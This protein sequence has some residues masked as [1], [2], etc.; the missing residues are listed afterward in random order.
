MATVW[1]VSEYLGC[2][3]ATKVFS[4]REK[5]YT[6][7][8][9]RARAI[10]QSMLEHESL[11]GLASFGTEGQDATDNFDIQQLESMDELIRNHA[12]KIDIGC[13]WA[14]IEISELPVV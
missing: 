12:S 10:Y 11:V 3:H 8:Y 6:Y 2:D 5:A 13:G 9:V 14:Q 7:V 1:L 4:T